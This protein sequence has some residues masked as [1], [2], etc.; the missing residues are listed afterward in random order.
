[1]ESRLKRFIY[2]SD[3]TTLKNDSESTSV[4]VAIPNG[5]SIAPGTA[6]TWSTDVSVGTTGA[7]MFVT[8]VWSGNN[9]YIPGEIVQY[10]YVGGLYGFTGYVFVSRPTSTTA[11]ITAILYN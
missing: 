5:Q 7:P 6:A 3:F 4:T 11:R 9:R 10:V 8:I 1:M 2:S